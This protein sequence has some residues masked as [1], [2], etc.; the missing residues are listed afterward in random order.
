[1]LCSDARPVCGRIMSTRPRRKATSCGGVGG[2]PSDASL[3]LT[4]RWRS[5]SV[6]SMA[7]IVRGGCVCLRC[8][9]AQ[10]VLRWGNA[11]LVACCCCGCGG[12]CWALLLWWHRCC[13]QALPPAGH[14]AGRLCE[15]QGQCM[16]SMMEAF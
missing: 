7:C 8:R 10:Q 9:Y 16:K 6:R 12:C 3:D 4:K 5:C 11:R 15:R 13:P 2:T 1:M 14:A